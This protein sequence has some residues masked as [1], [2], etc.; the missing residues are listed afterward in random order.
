LFILA[1][2]SGE[3]G[4]RDDHHPDTGIGIKP[5][6]LA[7]LFQPFRQIDSGLS[8]N[9]DGTGLGLTICRRLAEL[10]GGMICAESV[11][12]MGSTFCVTL[13]LKGSL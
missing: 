2:G 7:T 4:P 13:P 12:E 1:T 3:I 9:Y 10:M 11:P 5:D 6:E 8:R